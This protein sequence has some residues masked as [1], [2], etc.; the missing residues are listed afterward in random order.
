LFALVAA[1][2]EPRAIDGVELRGS[3]GSLREV[4]ETDRTVD[5]E[6][7]LF[8]FGLLEAFDIKPL[9]ALVAPRPVTFVDQANDTAGQ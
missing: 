9:A 3:F 1:A 4:I 5:K 6:P 8:C 7:E 2:L